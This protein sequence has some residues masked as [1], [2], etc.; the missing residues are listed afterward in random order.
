MM[1]I[2]VAI[3]LTD[4]AMASLSDRNPQNAF[5]KD[6]PKPQQR[7][8]G[9][10]E[11]RESRRFA[12][13]LPLRYRGDGQSGAGEVINISSS[14]VLFTTDSNQRPSGVLELFVSWPV[15]LNEAVS[16]NLVMVGPVVRTERAKAAVR[17]NKYEFRTAKA[18]AWKQDTPPGDSRAQSAPR[19]GA[20]LVRPAAQGLLSPQI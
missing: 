3:A 6:R 13:R 15:L 1:K 12:I 8:P 14:G 20:A 7:R 2:G 10:E 16:L 18:P 9:S 4:I 17:V 19:S 11:R 5:P